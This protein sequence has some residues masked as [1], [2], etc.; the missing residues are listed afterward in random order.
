M[1]GL[2]ERDERERAVDADAERLVAAILSFGVLIL[3]MVRSLRGEAA[4]DLMALVMAAGFAGLVYRIRHRVVDRRLGMLGL[5]VG[6]VSAVVAA[7][8]VAV[9]T[10]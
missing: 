1:N 2:V 3:V 9:M 8:I 6:V 7:V 10:R 5:V 4:W